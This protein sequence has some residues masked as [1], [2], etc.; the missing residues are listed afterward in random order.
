MLYTASLRLRTFGCSIF[1]SNL[2]DSLQEC[3]NVFGIDGQTAVRGGNPYGIHAPSANHI[4][5]AI[6]VQFLR[7][8]HESVIGL[9]TELFSFYLKFHTADREI[10]ETRIEEQKEHYV[11][12]VVVTSPEH[13]GEE[14]EKDIDCKEYDSVEPQKALAD[15]KIVFHRI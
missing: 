15:W 5:A 11:V 8:E 10:V 13:K 7:P 6:S 3:W 14:D 4:A 2:P 1:S 9:V 12:D